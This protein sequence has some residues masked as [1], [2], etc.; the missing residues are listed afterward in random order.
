MRIV[1]PR[2]VAQY[3]VDESAIPATGREVQ[4]ANCENIWFQDYIEMLP[5]RAG[6]ISPNADSKSVFDDLDDASEVNFH[7][8][9]SQAPEPP[10]ARPSAIETSDDEEV[11]NLLA[12]TSDEDEIDSFYDDEDEDD[13]DDQPATNI[14]LTPVNEDVLNVLRSEAAFSSASAAREQLDAAAANAID[15]DGEERKLAADQS[16]AERK[17]TETAVEPEE[18]EDPQEAVELE[19]AA[20]AD[21]GEEP[22]REET[23]ET[24]V[25]DP[26]DS[27]PDDTQTDT[28]DSDLDFADLTAFLD[29][30]S[31]AEQ[32]EEPEEEP[33]VEND[34]DLDEEDDNTPT[35][36]P[37]SDLDAI[38]SQLDTIGAER[39][40]NEDEDDDGIDYTPILPSDDPISNLSDEEEN[41]YD[42]ADSLETD[43]SV[44][45]DLDLSELDDTSDLLASVRSQSADAEAE[46]DDDFE[47]D[48]D[49]LDELD[50][51]RPRHAYRA[52]GAKSQDTDPDE[53]DLDPDDDDDGEDDDLDEEAVAHTSAAAATAA[54]VS[55][56]LGMSR[57]RAKNTQPRAR[58]MQGFGLSEGGQD[59]EFDPAL[60][61]APESFDAADLPEPTQAERKS[62]LPDVDELD[63]SLRSEADHPRRR[64]REMREAHEEEISRTSGGFRRAFVWTVFV[65]AVLFALYLLRPMIVSALPGAAVVLDPYAAAIDSLRLLIDKITGS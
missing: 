35:F 48:F 2:C 15:G 24:A 37:L 17:E 21:E 50:E 22:D 33:E 5:D 8:Q 11:E 65:F 32:S 44:T 25:E 16:F 31:D 7:S 36:D 46:T 61:D 28:D 20:K 13:G 14:P 26:E 43:D 64:D 42:Q 39:A 18:T 6:E 30:H 59:P 19:D 34:E 54:S 27:A 38:R 49:D 1:C 63:A 52:D 4:C 51:D 57:P 12:D 58:I 45:D 62:L 23:T 40:A 29:A 41:P 47:D 10:A 55:A 3:E 9:R 53:D 60:D 56:A